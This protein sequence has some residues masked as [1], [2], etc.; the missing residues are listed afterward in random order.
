MS[1]QHT[2]GPWQW[3]GDYT[4]RPANPR[5][6]LHTVHTILSPDGETFGFMSADYKDVLAENAANKVLM[7]SAPELLE[8]LKTTLGN[9]MSLGPAGALESVPMPFRVW[10]EVVKNAIDKAEGNV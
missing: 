3:D 8:A 2:P 1:A 7:A 10:A 4:L 9:I 5:P 6:E